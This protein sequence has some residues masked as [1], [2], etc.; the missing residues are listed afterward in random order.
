[1]ALLYYFE[2]KG[3]KYCK[4]PP[5]SYLSPYVMQRTWECCCAIYF[6]FIQCA[7][8][9]QKNT[10]SHLTVAQQKE[11]ILEQPSFNSCISFFANICT[12]KTKVFVIFEK[13][14][15]NSKD[16]LALFISWRRLMARLTRK[17]I[18]TY[19]RGRYSLQVINSFYK[20]AG[21]SAWE[22]RLSENVGNA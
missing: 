9:Q 16:L 17:F 22:W 18:K 13:Y 1:M 14:L 11:Q 15:E 20:F 4:L 12:I 21:I 19:G 8:P 5:F 2:E 7:V 3:S 6:P 10:R